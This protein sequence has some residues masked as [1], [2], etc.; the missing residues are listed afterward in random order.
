MATFGNL[1]TLVQI[2]VSAIFAVFS[3]LAGSTKTRITTSD[4]RNFVEGK[5]WNIGTCACAQTV[6]RSGYRDCLKAI[7]SKKVIKR[8]D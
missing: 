8:H 6:A 5:D 3:C 7:D 4:A 1:K 2:E